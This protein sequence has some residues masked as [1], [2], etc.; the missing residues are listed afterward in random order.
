[1]LWQ[2]RCGSLCEMQFISVVCGLAVIQKQ[3]RLVDRAFNRASPSHFPE[4]AFQALL[5]TSASLP[6]S[7]F[8]L[9]PFPP[10]HSSALSLF[11]NPAFLTQQAALICTI[12][13]Q[14][15]L[16]TSPE[17]WHLFLAADCSAQ[18]LSC[19]RRMQCFAQGSSLAKESEAVH[20][21]QPH[22]PWS[23]MPSGTSTNKSYC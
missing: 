5:Q 22:T 11:P 21:S 17:P 2:Y 9:L 8:W 19:S 7:H 20:I 12:A 15:A 23:H 18:G 3:P 13:L 6:V 10:T 1:M 16:L 14:A 4:P